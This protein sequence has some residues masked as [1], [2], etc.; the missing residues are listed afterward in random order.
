ME[1]T[2]EDLKQLKEHMEEC[3]QDDLGNNLDNKTIGNL[4]ARLEASERKNR[5][6]DAYDEFDCVHLCED[7]CKCGTIQQKLLK[8]VREA[9]EAWRKAAGK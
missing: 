9:Y 1:F 6:N 5:A 7:Q 3:R 4:L 2:D 8:E